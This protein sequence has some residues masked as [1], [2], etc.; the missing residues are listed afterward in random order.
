MH[1]NHVV[2]HRRPLVATAYLYRD[3][4]SCRRMLRDRDAFVLF[5]FF[6][7]ETPATAA[8]KLAMIRRE[9]P[10]IT[11]R[12][13]V[14]RVELFEALRGEFPVVL[15]HQNALVDARVF[16]PMPEVRLLYPA[17]YT[18]ATTPGKRHHLA[19]DIPGWLW[20]TYM[21][22]ADGMEHFERLR[23]ELRNVRIPQYAARYWYW[24]NRQIAYC[25][26]ESEVGLCLSEHEGGMWAVTEY[27][28]AGLPIVA[29]RDSV[30]GMH[31]VF[32]RDFVEYVAPDRAAVA[33]AA[34]A[35]AARRIPRQQI[36]DAAQAILRPHLD[37]L[38]GALQELCDLAGVATDIRG[39]WERLYFDKFY[40]WG[41]SPLLAD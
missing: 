20:I 3:A 25:L 16:R 18:A 7:Y 12:A 31:T 40:H 37:A 22:N 5:F 6:N 38:Q 23:G 39:A 17:V 15:A 14:D 36:R 8:D 35:L 30:G 41:E 26:N 24:D 34:R 32:P 9:Y 27:L 2:V 28:L 33:R 21:P 29:T 13:A 1:T 10:R 4:E 11:F 19:D